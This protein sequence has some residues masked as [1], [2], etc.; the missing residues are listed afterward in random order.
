MD[1][2][3]FFCDKLD[4]FGYHELMSDFRTLPTG[5]WQ[6][7]LVVQKSKFIAFAARVE[8]VEAAQAF[9]KS[10]ALSDATHHCY[11]YVTAD[12]QKSND[13]GEPAGTAGLPI[14]Q[15]IKQQN[16][17]HVAVAVERYFG[18]IKLGTG[19]LARAYGQAANQ[20]LT[21]VAPVWMRECAVLEVMSNYEQQGAVAQLVAVCGK[22]LAVEYQDLIKWRV[23][24]PVER[25]NEFLGELGQILRGTPAVVVLEPRTWVEFPVS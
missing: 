25:E 1:A 20:V 23:A 10:V 18:G 22:E 4:G 11:A 24:V 9:L 3:Y 6:Q 15:A 5:I 7:T 14:L 16:L 13:N 21:A 12:G 8:N 2:G 17:S 19:G